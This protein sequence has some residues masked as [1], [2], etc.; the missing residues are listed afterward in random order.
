MYLGLVPLISS[1]YSLKTERNANLFS[2]LSS[3][4][5]ILLEVVNDGEEDAAGLIGDGV[6]TV[7]TCHSLREGG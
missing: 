3:F 2:T 7:R 5:Q 6:N 4:E 1:G